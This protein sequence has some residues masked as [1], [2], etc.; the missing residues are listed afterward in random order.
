MSVSR[1][2]PQCEGKVVTYLVTASRQYATRLLAPR[3][4][5]AKWFAAVT[6]DWYRCSDQP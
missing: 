6:I 1:V 2:W 4:L 3:Y 5:Y